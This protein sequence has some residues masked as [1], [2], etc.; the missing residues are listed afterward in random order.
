MLSLN[1]KLWT[2]LTSL[3]HPEHDRH[4]SICADNVPLRECTLNNATIG[5]TA[6]DVMGFNDFKM[7]VYTKDVTEAERKIHTFGDALSHCPLPY[8]L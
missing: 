6:N 3:K 5:I 7:R 4:L 8:C 1:L 2:P